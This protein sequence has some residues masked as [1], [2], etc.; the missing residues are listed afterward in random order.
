MVTCTSPPP[1][2]LPSS[3]SASVCVQPGDPASHVYNPARLKVLQACII[4]TGTIDFI[5]H[6]A[7]GDYHIGLALDPQ[8]AALVNDCNAT[9]LGGVE[10][11]DLVVEPVCVVSA[12]QADALPACADYHNPLVIPP[13]G[14]HVSMQGALVVDLIHG[15][16]EIHPLV[17]V[18]VV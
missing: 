17:A 4:V 11:G 3:P 2:A 18:H 6:E 15:W 12:T 7:D 14:S 5:R 13:V 9:C 8:F 1:P 10:H 16:V